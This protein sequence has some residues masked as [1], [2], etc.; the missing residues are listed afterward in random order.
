MEND[1]VVLV[2]SFIRFSN[3]FLKN[4]ASKLFT[5]GIS[6]AILSGL[7]FLSSSVIF[8]IKFGI[9]IYSMCIESC[10]LAVLTQVYT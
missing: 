1:I 3:T 9:S 6:A 2:A 10:V 4:Y 8:D 7:L 5:E